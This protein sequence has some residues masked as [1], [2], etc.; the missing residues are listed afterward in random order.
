ML[1]QFHDGRLHHRRHQR[2]RFAD[3][4]PVDGQDSQKFLVAVDDEQ[5]VGLRRQFIEATQ[6]AQY[7]LERH[8]RAHLQVLEVHQR[9]DHVVVEGHRRAQLFAFL[10]REAGE[11]I[12]HHL[13]W[14]I[15]RQVGDF[16]GVERLGGGDEFLGVHRRDQ[17]F[18]DRVGNLEQDLAVARR[19]HQV[20]DVQALV[21]RQRLEDVRDVGRVQAVE[22]A[23]Q[24]RAILLG[25]EALDDLAAAG[26][27]ADRSVLELLVHQALDQPMLAQQRGNLG[28]R[29]LHAFACFGALDFLR[30]DGF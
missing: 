7:D 14:E 10:Q 13:L 9:A 28:E 27:G 4:Q 16:L 25:D 12:V 1:Q 8:F 2:V 30:C 17:R 23:R 22:L 21:E 19:A 24:L 18:A 3:D 29:V 15:R 20:P 5:L 6:I 11:H 26:A